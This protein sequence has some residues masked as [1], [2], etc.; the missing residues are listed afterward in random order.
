MQPQG[1]DIELS[2][3]LKAHPP[4]TARPERVPPS[5][6]ESLLAW[7]GVIQRIEEDVG[8]NEDGSGHGPR[9]A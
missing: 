5:A 4:Q 7:V 2:Q 6:R 9:L 1:I 8:V 3:H